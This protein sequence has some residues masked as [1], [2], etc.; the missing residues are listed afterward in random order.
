MSFRAPQF[1]VKS[2]MEQDCWEQKRHLYAKWIALQAFNGFRQEKRASRRRHQTQSGDG[3]GRE[4]TC[5][6]RDGL[7]PPRILNA[8]TG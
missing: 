7:M 3:P 8:P 6:L 1:A 2:E 4:L 5:H